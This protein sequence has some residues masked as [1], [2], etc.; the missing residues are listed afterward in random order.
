MSGVLLGAFCGELVRAEISAVRPLVQAMRA[1]A[2]LL[3]L[4]LT[5]L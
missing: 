1:G 2:S 4:P 5:L 3:P